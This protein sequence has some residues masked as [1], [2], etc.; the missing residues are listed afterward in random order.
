MRITRSV[1]A[2]PAWLKSGRVLVGLTII[3]IVAICAIFAPYLAPHDPSE[4][5]LLAMLL[6][7]AW[8]QGGDAAY[9]LGTDSLGRC[10]LSR[11]IYGAR[12][13]LTV[14]FLASIGAMSLGAVLAH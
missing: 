8:A 3:S 6:P 4:Q 2:I 14:A 13:A 11:L 9:P 12:V 10:V 7:P 5:D 1:S